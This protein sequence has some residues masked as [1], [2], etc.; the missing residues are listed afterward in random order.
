MRATLPAPA[1]GD[2][3]AHRAAAIPPAAE[4]AEPAEP[5][6]VTAELTR[7][8]FDREER[9]RV[10]ADWR[11]LL[12][13]PEFR[14]V[15]GLSREARTALAYDRLRLV[16]RTVDAE[17]LARDP[18][19]LASLHEWAGVS[20]GSLV[21]LSSIHYNL[22]LGSLLDQD[23]ADRRDLS[24]FTS[25]R[26]V[27][28]FLCTELDHGNDASALRT[29]ATLDRETGGFVLHTPDAG[30]Q[31]FMP[32]T[33]PT[34][35][36]KS[37]VVAA[38]LLI[39]G[40]DQGVFLFLTPLSDASGMLPG[41]HVRRLPER[42]G[43]PVDHCLTAFDQVRLPPDALL[44]GDHG[45]LGA[46]GAF[47]SGVGSRRK[48]FL[49]A[50]GRVTTGKLCMSAAAIGVSRAALTI[51]VRHAQ[52]RHISGPRSGERIPLAAH[53]SHHARL[54]HGLA[55]EYA[56]VFLHRTVLDRWVGHTPE[57]RDEVERLAAVAKGWITWQARDITTECRERCG[58]QGLFM[59]NAIADYQANLEGTITAEGDNLV[60]WLKAAAE[61]IFSYDAG[62]PA[63]RPV[64]AE[65]PL[66]D[67]AF[68]RGLLG[69]V[70]RIWQARARTALREG[71]R[72]DPVGRWNGTSTPALELVAAHA[73]CQ[74]ADAFLTAAERATD[75]TAARLLRS[76]CRLFLLRQLAPHTG[77]L[78]AHGRLTPGHV[79]AWSLTTDATVATLAPHLG[80]LADAFDLP[81]EALSDIPLAG[82]H[83]HIA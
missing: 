47:D 10:H 77:D 64:D 40:A 48:R 69:D 3:T 7:L 50:I 14:H 35:G 41:V 44:Q 55:T 24:D 22:F 79:D 73:L 60:V 20:D 61:M 72:R 21:T 56:M 62:E 82:P 54:L 46:D 33:S 13:R 12:A 65:Q 38:R 81:E 5:A 78:L 68:L 42:L 39:D 43:S 51:A 83:P 67:L 23:G 4:P 76:L 57:E 59:V 70:E 53:R 45:Q 31:K 49:H 19:R 58:A 71:P 25:M 27:G 18:H 66:T 36:P 2:P 63:A 34:G 28:T 26:R 29:T 52:H 75:P 8:L 80:T 6:P 16:N 74:A 37:A 32:N 1:H 15:P 17:Q 30:A 9:D 11:K